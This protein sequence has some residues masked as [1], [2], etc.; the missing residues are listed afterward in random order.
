M[1]A[2][3]PSGMVARA[4]DWAGTPQPHQVYG[5]ALPADALQCWHMLAVGSGVAACSGE[6]GRYRRL[7]RIL[8][9]IPSF[10][11]GG[12]ERQCA[13]LCAELAKRGHEVHVA[14]VLPCATGY[15]DE[16]RQAGVRLHPLGAGLPPDIWRA[17]KSPRVLWRLLRV[18][19]RERPEIVQS[20]NRPMDTFCGVARRV[21]R[22]PVKFLTAAS[23]QR[24]RHW[25][26]DW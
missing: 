8:H 23:L 1:G 6:S 22:F 26:W 2:T 11:S 24:T 18:V 15:L 13:L 9:C 3:Q 14:Y 12:A 25:S 10:G 4:G 5:I 19:R 20:W 17:Q 7:M 16:L 21:V